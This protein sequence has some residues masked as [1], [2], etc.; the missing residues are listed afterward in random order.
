[1]M[2]TNSGAVYRAEEES[3]R[4]AVDE[5]I[6]HDWPDYVRDAERRRQAQRRLDLLLRGE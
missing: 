1:M 5:T 2:R 6:G 3:V 4:E